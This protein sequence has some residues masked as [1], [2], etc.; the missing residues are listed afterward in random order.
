VT[1]NDYNRIGSIY[2]AE[3]M[4]SG[5]SMVI[6]E[7]GQA[8]PMDWE[9]DAAAL[10]AGF[11]IALLTSP[12]GVSGAVFLAPVQLSVLHV[13]NPQL[14]PT[15]L[16]YNLVS[17]PGALV[18]YTRQRRVDWALTRAMVVGSLPGV[19]LGAYLRVHVASDPAA[20]QLVAATVLLPTGILLLRRRAPAPPAPPAPAVDES[21]GGAATG[22][23]GP[24]S[25]RP[26]TITALA[27]VVGIAGG[28]YGIGGGSL[29]G[30]I[31]VAMGASLV[32]V[33]PAALASTYLTSAAGAAAFAVLS[34]GAPG[35]VG[36]DVS[37]G[38]A[39]GL[40]GLVGGYLGARV[41]PRLPETLLRR[42]LAVAAVA[43]AAT[44]LTLGLGSL[45]D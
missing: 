21:A 18:R 31:L 6:H 12:V 24:S 38:V 19:V 28:L 43:L 36:P 9:R 14:T 42:G 25:P 4:D 23:T 5:V 17:G 11:V 20:F 2:N 44:Y 29:L 27:F 8:K 34:I 45:L 33:A 39:A 26:R 15:N 10:A 35:D 32:A 22:P 30:P 16:L 40:G 41:Q 3:I 13:P 7:R 1:G 37:L